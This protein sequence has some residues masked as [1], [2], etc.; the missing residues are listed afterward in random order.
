MGPE[1]NWLDL[2]KATG[3][4]FGCLAVAAWL[5]V[6][7]DKFGWLP[8]TLDPMFKQGTMLAAIALT[9]LW[10]ASIGT[11]ASK[12]SAVPVEKIKRHLAM[13][14]HAKSFQDYIPYM[15]EDER[16]VFAQLLH[17]NRK[18]F[19]AADDGGYA[20]PLI[21]RGYIHVVA[22]HGQMLSLENVPFAVSD[23]IW[24]VAVKQKDAFPYTPSESGADAWRVHWMAR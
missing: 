18:S 6:F 17:E 22:R 19:T 4:Q 23:H 15:T 13:R 5:A 8:V 10:I 1:A 16:A 9:A 7:A 14:A 12:W 11:T 24:D 20:G 21:G 3:W 2:L